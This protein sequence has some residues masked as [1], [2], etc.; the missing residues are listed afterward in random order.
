[1]A[2]SDK[3]HISNIPLK[4]YLFILFI[5]LCM[6]VCEGTHGNQ[7]MDLPGVGTMGNFD[8]LNMLG[9]EFRFSNRAVNA[10]NS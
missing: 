2:R 5:H 3:A 1:M 10:P 7:R 4:I 9:T 8:L 6:C